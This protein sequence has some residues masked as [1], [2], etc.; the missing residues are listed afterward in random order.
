MPADE[1]CPENF[2]DIREA[3]VVQDAVDVLLVILA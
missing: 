3:L 2:P 1:F